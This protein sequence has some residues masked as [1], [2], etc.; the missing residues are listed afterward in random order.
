MVPPQCFHFHGTVNT[1]TFVNNATLNIYNS[2]TVCQCNS[3]I[4][5]CSGHHQQQ[6][7]NNKGDVGGFK[8][9]NNNEDGRKRKTAS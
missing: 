7:N 9:Q 5:Q 6:S 1:N 8:S 4:N 2:D 3:G